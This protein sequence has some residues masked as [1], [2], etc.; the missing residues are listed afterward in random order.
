[1]RV[2]AFQLTRG[3][4]R[5]RVLLVGVSLAGLL[6]AVATGG[7]AQATTALG[8]QF[9]LEGNAVDNTAANPPIDWAN[10]YAAAVPG[11]D[12]TGIAPDQPATD[13]SYFT[14]GGS[15]DPQDVPNWRF[16]SNSAPA[17]DEITD[18]FGAAVTTNGEKTIYFGADRYDN[19]GD[20]QIGFW[21]FQN[22]VSASGGKFT[23]VHQAPDSTH[24][25]GDLLVLSD[26]TN[27]GRIGTVNV[28][29][30]VGSGGSD[31]A[32]NHIFP[33]PNTTPVVDC[34]DPAAS[35][36]V[37]GTVNTAD[38]VTSPWPYKNKSKQTTFAHGEFYEGGINLGLLLPGGNP[39]F[40]SFLAETRSSQSP[41]A[42][43]KDF[44]LHS[45]EPCNPSTTMTA[46]AATASPSVVHA[47]ETSTL[48][49][50]ET[51]DGNVALTSPS[52]TIPDDAGC[53]ATIAYVSGD[54]DTNGKLDGGETWMFACTTSFT[55]A[56]SKTVTA[57]GHGTSVLGDVTFCVTPDSTKVCDAD[58]MTTVSVTVI[59]P[60]T[61]LTKTA[62]A[63]VTYTFKESNTGDAPLSSPSVTDANCSTAPAYSSGDSLVTGTVGKLDPGETWVFTCTQTLAGPTTDTGTAST[64]NTA[65]G[66]GSDAATSSKDV[67]WCADPTTPS[68]GVYCSQQERDR[69]TVTIEN[70]A[71]G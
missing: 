25:H 47:N 60:S 7:S 46:T 67:T 11:F 2:G 28:Y 37:C 61:E 6:A 48:T 1:M 10:L 23:G 50:Y 26:F 12:F 3:D 9:E 13:A 22:A 36:D 59:N 24:L 62:S 65:V 71:R 40:A 56:G 58:E 38:G 52:V 5:G 55:T 4:R 20:S 29:E 68:S 53:A 14:G 18:A 17:K 54:T 30:W 8:G 69:V 34:Q 35:D 19:S 44:V 31:G 45:F 21:F 43:L 15:K 57:I 32:I 16:N 49:F 27:G 64:T 33:D 39:C 51:N 70:L 63:V 66:H 41:S 42:V